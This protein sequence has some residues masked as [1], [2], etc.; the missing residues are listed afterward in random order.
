MNSYERFYRCHVCQWQGRQEPESPAG[1]IYCPQ[2]GLWL[3]PSTTI[4]T[5]PMAVL[6]MLATIGLVALMAFGF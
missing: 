4:A 5:W 2:C 3:Q 1:E 6:I